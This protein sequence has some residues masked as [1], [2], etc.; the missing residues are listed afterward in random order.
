MK[1]FSLILGILVFS[2]SVA[3][4]QATS[5]NGALLLSPPTPSVTQA[6]ANPLFSSALRGAML[7]SARP[8][9]APAPQEV[10]GVFPTLYWQ[11]S[12]GFT[13]MRFYELPNATVT[14]N[15]F[16]MSMAYF[17]KERIGAEGELEGG[18]GAASAK[19]VFSGGG[20]RYRI[21]GPRA[22]Q[23]WIHAVAG[24]AHY[25]PKTTYGSD[26]TFGY[27]AGGGVDFTAHHQKLAYRLGAD[28]LGTTFFGT[29]Q[30][31]PKISAGIVYKF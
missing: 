29:Y 28:L 22:L 15:G 14:T 10:Q 23:L 4:A 30:I 24:E 5:S 31:S 13:Y 12:V 20:L 19:M 7:A 8:A 16:N 17:F 2:A 21:A 27:E 9:P 1:R 6:F 26:S 25:L 3:S 11:A 18:V